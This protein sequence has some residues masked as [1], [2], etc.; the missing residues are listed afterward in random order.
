MTQHQGITKVAENYYDS[1]DADAFYLQIWGG[2]DIHVGLYQSDEEP[3]RE[4][5]RRTV[6]EMASRLTLGPDTALLD[7]GSGF[8]GAVRHLVAKYGLKEVVALNLSTAQNRRHRQMNEAAGIADHVRVVDGAFESIPGPDQSFDVVWCQDSILH[9]GEKARVLQE[10]DRVLKPG[11][12]FIFTDPMQA[13]DC[14]EGVLGPVL[15][16]IHLKEMGSFA[17]YR[18]IARELGWQEV[19]VDDHS[20]QLPRHYARVRTELVKNEESLRKV[21]S[22]T[23]LESMKK[24]LQHWVDAGK[25]GHLAWGII[26]FRKPL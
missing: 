8:G 9:S 13:D 23:Y 21:C 15:A 17:S 24:G 4:A 18:G 3:I 25:A 16:R 7:I 5:S 19:A 20:H 10:V 11:G 26:H 12:Q 6:D 14:P 22:E 2:E 1:S